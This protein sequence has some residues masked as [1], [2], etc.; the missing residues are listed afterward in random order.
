MMF[1]QP[2]FYN[3]FNLP[4]HIYLVGLAAAIPKIDLFISL[5]GAVAS[6][7]L[8]LIA[9]SIMHTLVFWDTFDGMVG[10]IKIGRNLFLCILGIIGMVFGTIYSIKDI[11]EYFINP[12]EEGSY[13]KCEDT[14]DLTTLASNRNGYFI[15]IQ[16]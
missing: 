10:K 1:K 3:R 16:I 6:S 2:L 11:I 12:S 13:P 14:Q 5:I 8:A 15:P 4:F 7:T 9:P